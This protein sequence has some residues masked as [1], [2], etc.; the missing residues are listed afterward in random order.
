[1]DYVIFK[2]TQISTQGFYVERYF[3]FAYNKAETRFIDVKKLP[4]SKGLSQLK[5]FLVKKGAKLRQWSK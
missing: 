1:M 4:S 5:I 3:Y 2:T